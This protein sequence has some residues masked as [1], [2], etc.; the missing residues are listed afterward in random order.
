MEF[1][2]ASTEGVIG[3]VGKISGDC[4]GNCFGRKKKNVLFSLWCIVGYFAHYCH[5]SGKIIM[6]SKRI[7]KF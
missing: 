4:S 3:V 5:F 2:V 7:G 1:R 6:L